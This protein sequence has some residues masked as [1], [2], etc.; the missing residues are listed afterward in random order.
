MLTYLCTCVMFFLS[1]TNTTNL[2]SNNGI[3][4]KR[5]SRESSPRP[6]IELRHINPFTPERF[7]VLGDLRL[8]WGALKVRQPLLR[9]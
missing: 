8:H 5:V 1:T 4:D 3:V 6:L 9:C 7:Q 2:S